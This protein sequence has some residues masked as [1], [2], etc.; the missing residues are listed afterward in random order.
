[1]KQFNLEEYLKN[2]LRKVVTRDGRNIK[3][4]CTNYYLSNQCVIAEIEDIGRSFSF[5][6]YGQQY[7]NTEDSPLNLFF[8]SEKNEGKW[9]IFRGEVPHN[10]VLRELMSASIFVFPS[11]TEGFPNVILEA[12]ACGCPIVSTKVGAIP[13]MLDIQRGYNY[14][15]C[16]EPQDTNM[17]FDGLKE[18]YQNPDYANRCAKRA[19]K[20]VNEMY[21]VPVVWEQLVK[22]WRS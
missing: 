1:M 9:C 3:I 18:M 14:G 2:P 8:A 4:L 15:I 6:Q 10:Q 13:E 16:V 21:A 11:Y 5:N 22:I 12:M 20:R 7:G 17:F 19:E